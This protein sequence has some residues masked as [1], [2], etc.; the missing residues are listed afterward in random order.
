MRK[1]KY[2][3]RVEINFTYLCQEIV[4]LMKDFIYDF[5]VVLVLAHIQAFVCDLHEALRFSDNT[6]THVTY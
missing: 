6:W 3:S 1:Q 4:F 5:I 2:I